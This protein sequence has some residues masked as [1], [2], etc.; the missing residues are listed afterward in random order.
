MKS[1][2]AALSATLMLG[3]LGSCSTT[4]N[5]Q[6]SGS[7]SSST[8]SP[9]STPGEKEYM[10][11]SL[12][13]FDFEGTDLSV[14]L[15]LPSDLLTKDYKEG[16][17]LL[18]VPD[19]ED[20]EKEIK[21]YLSYFK[22]QIE[23]PA[24]ATVQDGDTVVMDYVGKMDGVAFAGGSA[25]DSSHTISLENS[26]FIDGFDRGLIGMKEGETKDLYLTFPDPYTP[27]T[28]LSGKAVVFT[29]TIDKIIRYEIPELTDQLVTD[30]KDYFGENIKT[31]A[32]FREQVKN[33]LVDYFK[34]TDNNN[35]IDSAWKYVTENSTV[36]AYP[37][38][39]LDGY[40][41]AMYASFYNNALQYS[42]TPDEFAQTK[43][44]L[45]AADYKKGVLDPKAEAYLKETMTLYAA[46]K[47]ASV[48]V[49]DEEIRATAEKEF[50]TNIEPN[51]SLY[52]AYGI[53]DL[54][55][56][57]EYMG[58]SYF[59]EP[60]MF[61]TLLS[62]LTGIELKQNTENEENQT[63]SSDTQKS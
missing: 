52:S 10:D 38:G 45:S 17:E 44:Y 31:A 15:T 1:I 50:K 46:A 48:T 28:S 35:I 32:D 13:E 47:A 57:I 56:F 11:A 62:K 16:L 49:T 23:T 34:A 58:V 7:A 33:Y 55:S 41:D 14:Y 21:S 5:P 24:D 20:I 18:G 51:L 29:V 40:K 22:T 9:S 26:S 61:N 30:K 39:L 3:L 59:K 4:P 63:E 27:N 19:E 54:D 8:Q 6:S 36:I 37:D 53:T 42:M 12:P 43:G 25:T 60:M 2:S